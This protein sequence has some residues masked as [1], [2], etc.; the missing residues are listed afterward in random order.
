[1]A[2]AFGEHIPREDRDRLGALL[3]RVR[4]ESGLQ[5]RELAARLNVP[6]SLLSKIEAGERGFD[7]LEVRVVC[8]AL[9]VPFVEFAE[10]LDKM[11]SGEGRM[12]RPPDPTPR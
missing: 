1:M 10:R 7:V 11:L 12:E 2:R 6:S 3:R 8:D 4:V 5:Q 9:G